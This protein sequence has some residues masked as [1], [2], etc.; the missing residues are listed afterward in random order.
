MKMRWLG[1]I[2]FGDALAI[3]LCDEDTALICGRRQVEDICVV[4]DHRFPS[5]HCLKDALSE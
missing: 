3:R 5:G 2:S 4:Y 1:R